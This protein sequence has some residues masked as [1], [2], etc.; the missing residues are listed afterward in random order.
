[1]LKLTHNLIS[2]NGGAQHP[3]T[4][5]NFKQRKT[6]TQLDRWLSWLPLK[7]RKIWRHW[8]KRRT[9]VIRNVIIKLQPQIVSRFQNT[10]LNLELTFK[11][12]SLFNFDA[13]LCLDLAL[14]S[15]NNWHWVKSFPIWNPWTCL[16]TSKIHH[17]GVKLGA[18]FKYLR[19]EARKLSLR[20]Y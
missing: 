7:F 19:F 12:T 5:I 17:I 16:A 11:S 3:I 9:L 13:T 4:R 14:P 18:H 20:G 6:K 15:S 1:M 10:V 8:T 2:S